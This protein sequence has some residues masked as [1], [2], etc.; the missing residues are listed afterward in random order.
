[1]KHV[2]LLLTLLILPETLL[3]QPATVKRPR[4]QLINGSDQPVDV[5]WVNEAGDHVPNGRI[6]PGDETTI[7]TTLGHRFV[8]VAAN[9]Q[10]RTEVTC[11]VPVQAFRFDFRNTN[12]VPDF[13]TQQI[14]ANGYPI[15]ASAAVNPFALHEAAYLIDLM[16]AKRPDVR[17]AMIRS[18]SRLCII[19]WNEF[20]TDQ[21]EFARLARSPLPDFPGLDPKD[22][23][24]ARARGL[25]GSPTDPLC[26]CGEE[27]LLCY[28]GDPYSTENILIHEFA[29]NIHLRGMLNVDP[30]FDS[31]LQATYETAMQAGL[32]KGKYAS[33]NHH[34]YFAE[35]V[36][37]WFDNNR[38]NDHDHN[39]V[40]TRT[41][42]LEY[43]PG[44]A[45]ICREV[46]GE[47]QLRYTKP[48]TRLTDH[49]QGYDPS[50]A[51]VFAWPKRLQHAQQLIRENAKARSD[52]ATKTNKPQRPE[53]PARPNLPDEFLTVAESSGFEA[54]SLSIDV[55]RFLTACDDKAAHV[56]RFE[57]GQTSLGQPLTG[58]T[59]ANPP[60]TDRDT[61]QRL[62]ILLLGNIHSGECDGKEA[63]LMLTRELTLNPN[64]PWLQHMSIIVVPNY[65]ADGNDKVATDNRPGQIGPIR[66]M[67]T[68]ETA[69]GFDLNRDFMKLETPEGQSLVRLINH[70]DPQILIDCHTTNGSKHRYQLTYDIPHNPASPTALRTLL[71]D[72]LLPDVTAQMKTDGYDTFYYGNFSQNHTRWE[73]YGFEP[74]YSTEYMGIRGRIGILS[75]SYSYVDYQTRIHATRAF[76]RNCLDYAA[77]NAD[78]I[79]S[80]I[81][82]SDSDWLDHTTASPTAVSLPLDA[83]QQPFEK[84]ATVLGLAADSNQPQDYEVEFWGNYIG[85]NAVALPRAW[86][87][88]AAQE[89]AITNLSTH[90]IQFET[91]SKPFTAMVGVHQIQSIR[92]NSRPFQGHQMLLLSTTENV[93]LREIPAGTLIVPAAQPLG[94]L[95]ALLLEPSAT[96]GLAAWNYFDDVIHEGGEYPV[97]RLDPPESGTT[98]AVR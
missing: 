78:L 21:P 39:H 19:A 62:V 89:R 2:L 79:R 43:D 55:N 38:E 35:G 57:F 59:I 83:V 90:G 64:H 23:W 93:A 51:P 67:G 40:N 36:Q 25:G 6:L 92:R 9:D 12:G 53:Q 3:A 24:D 58:V 45:E 42:L 94:R 17:D 84:K 1:M 75:E 14:T 66:G 68:R 81:K 10:S 77:A 50:E 95:A 87:V 26:S 72:S 96:D 52:A 16:L 18:G 33:V 48:Q 49:L 22:F 44:L 34:E 85:T 13:Y 61:E 60:M 73:T 56:E 91:V 5:F 76:V 86:L 31:R 80:A 82:R 71:R 69:Q 74:R 47:T 27:N 54:T 65:N 97:L 4:L 37:S 32:W 8:L 28:A 46:F 88:P 20:T 30:T 29:H 7:T 63:L 41:E 70:W 98:Q 15:V 11:Q